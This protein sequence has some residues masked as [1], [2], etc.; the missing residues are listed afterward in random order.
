MLLLIHCG[1]ERSLSVTRQPVTNHKD[2]VM[3]PCP[4]PYLQVD[5]Q[6]MLRLYDFFSGQGWI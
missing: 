2:R 4:V 5:V 6:R 3:C 1:Q